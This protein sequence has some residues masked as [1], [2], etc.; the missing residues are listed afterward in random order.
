MF[1]SLSITNITFFIS[2]F[3]TEIFAELK[4]SIVL[5]S[6]A[7]LP[8]RTIATKKLIY[9]SNLKPLT[10]FNRYIS[11]LYFQKEKLSFTIFLEGVIMKLPIY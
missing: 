6:P 5:D 11:Y 9:S 10:D 1:E 3:G 7:F 8:Y 4:K 2:D